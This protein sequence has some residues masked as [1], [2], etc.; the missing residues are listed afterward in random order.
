M[1]KTIDLDIP[2]SVKLLDRS[3]WSHGEPSYM[4]E[5]VTWY[6]DGSKMAAGTGAG[7]YR[8]RPRVSMSRSLGKYATVFQA[9]IAALTECAWMNVEEGHKGKTIYMNSDSRAALMALA[10]HSYTSRVVWDC[11]NALKLLAKTNKVAVLWVPGHT[12]VRGNEEADRCARE[13]AETVLVGPEPACGIAYSMARAS[14]SRWVSSEHQKHWDHTDGQR[15]AKRMLKGPTRSVRADILKMARKDL[16]KVVGFITGHWSFYGHLHRMGIHVTSLLCRKCGE[17][18]E[19]AG[20]I[21]FECPA[22]CLRRLR[23][24]EV[25]SEG[26]DQ[27]DNIVQRSQGSVQAWD[28][29]A[30]KVAVKGGEK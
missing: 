10:S 17:V 1:T 20:H 23:S 27:Q 11:H 28:L 4:K 18:E 7:I 22:L 21:L 5:G 26:G 25:E 8:A 16:R 12:G 3:E 14:V 9:E 15:I 29:T 24:L 13:G 2:Y 30:C 6:T 19:T